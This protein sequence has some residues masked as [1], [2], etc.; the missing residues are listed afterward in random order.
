MDIKEVKLEK[1]RLE[2][3][4]LEAMVRFEHITETY[5]ES[6]HIDRVYPIG[7]E[8]GEIIS[9]KIVCDIGGRY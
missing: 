7:A 6:V 1:R 5:A 9:V 8:C 3:E 2:L 4:V